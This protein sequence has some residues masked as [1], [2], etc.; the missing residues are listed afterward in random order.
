MGNQKN[1]K[2]EIDEKLG[3]WLLGQVYTPSLDVL[4]GLTRTA[5][6]R[7]QCNAFI[8][9][10]AQEL[11]R[12][13]TVSK[14]SQILYTENYKKWHSN[15]TNMGSIGK[16]IM[17]VDKLINEKQWL[18]EIRAGKTIDYSKYRGENKKGE[19]YSADELAGIKSTLVDEKTDKKFEIPAIGKLPSIQ[20][21]FHY[22]MNRRSTI[23]DVLLKTFEVVQGIIQV[24]SDDTE[25]QTPAKVRFQ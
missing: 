22:L 8:R 24:G 3:R 20:Y 6:D 4:E 25:G 10:Y 1:N 7:V 5:L 12:L 2:S 14:K 13:C 19:I 23:P 21:L 15:D 16:R 17:P 18:V 9:V 11:L